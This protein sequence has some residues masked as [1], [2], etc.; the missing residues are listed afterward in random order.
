LRCYTQR[1]LTWFNCVTLCH[2][3]NFN[4]ALLINRKDQLL[5]F[6]WVHVVRRISHNLN[7][8][9]TWCSRKFLV[10]LIIIKASTWAGCSK[11]T[12]RMQFSWWTAEGG[13]MTKITQ[14]EARLHVF[15]WYILSD[16]VEKNTVDSVYFS[17]MSCICFC[18]TWYIVNLAQFYC[19]FFFYTFS[20]I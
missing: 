20:D 17:H 5:T 3:V 2:W 14:N 4:W 8:C 16:A 12:V 18:I 10:P 9:S 1:T 13:R 6:V 7:V 11:R 15:L 19:F